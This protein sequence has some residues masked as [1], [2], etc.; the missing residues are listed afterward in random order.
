MLVNDQA[1]NIP[2]GAV[3][4]LISTSRTLLDLGIGY[5][6]NHSVLLVQAFLLG[7]HSDP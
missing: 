6:T 3:A 1:R 5:I 2:S 7:P 4:T